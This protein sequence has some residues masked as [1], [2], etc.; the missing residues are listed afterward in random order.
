MGK[1][2]I[3]K[4]AIMI[5]KSKLRKYLKQVIDLNYK[6][7]DNIDIRAKIIEPFDSEISIKFKTNF[8]CPSALLKNK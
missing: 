5:P 4:G 2:K 6:N 3:F 8:K 7:I 1:K